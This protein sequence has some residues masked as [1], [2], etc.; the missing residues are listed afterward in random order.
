MLTP[1]SNYLWGSM[2]TECDQCPWHTVTNSEESLIPLCEK[3][4]HIWIFNSGL[5]RVD[6]VTNRATGVPCPHRQQQEH[7]PLRFN[8]DINA[9]FRFVQNTSS[10]DTVDLFLD[11]GI[12]FDSHHYLGWI[13][14][15]TTSKSLCSFNSSIIEQARRLIP[16]LATEE[17]LVPTRFERITREDDT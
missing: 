5:L 12:Y 11:Y 6:L 8:L 10:M 7:Q 1:S 3:G 14:Q 13:N 17:H 2:P 9:R 4:E 15:I 16:C